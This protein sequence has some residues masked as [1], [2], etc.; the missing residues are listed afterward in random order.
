MNEPVYCKPC[1]KKFKNESSH[2][3]HLP[4]KQH[5]KNASTFKEKVIDENKKIDILEDGE[6]REPRGSTATDA[7]VCLFSGKIHNSVEENLKS[8]YHKYGF[9]L[10]EQDSVMDREG[11][12]RFIGKIINVDMICII[13]GKLAFNRRKKIQGSQGCSKPHD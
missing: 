4:S 10:L 9:F 2:K 3:A 13:C 8:M 11:L 7:K 5:I 12:L 1:K 6:E